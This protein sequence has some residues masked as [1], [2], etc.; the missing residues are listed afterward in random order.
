MVF[1]YPGLYVRL[2]EVARQN[3][4]HKPRHMEQIQVCFCR[5]RCLKERLDAN[6][7]E[8]NLASWEFIA[9]LRV[10]QF[11]LG[12]GRALAD[13]YERITI[14]L[15]FEA[16]KI[17]KDRAVAR[18]YINFCYKKACPANALVKLFALIYF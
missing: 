2:D 4:C 1:T 3:K 14:A 11:L 18:I 13:S 8:S 9:T 12:N 17:E 16:P 6:D 5:G 15:T 10:L 7:F